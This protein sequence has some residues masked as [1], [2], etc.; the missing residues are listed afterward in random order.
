VPLKHF[1]TSICSWVTQTSNTSLYLHAPLLL[2]VWSKSVSNEGQFTLE[3]E[4]VFRRYVASHFSWVTETANIA[5][6][7][8][9]AQTMQ[10]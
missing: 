6:P 1:F 9:V 7:P 3:A 8:H 4:T 10:V 5:L 2:L